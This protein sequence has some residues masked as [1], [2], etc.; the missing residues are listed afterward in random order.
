MAGKLKRRIL[1]VLGVGALALTMTYLVVGFLILPLAV[2]TL[3]PK[4]AND[5]INGEVAIGSVTINPISF[6]VQI[7]DIK[8]ADQEG[9]ELLELELIRFNINVLK[10]IFSLKPC[11]Q[12][13]SLRGG[14]VNVVRD[15]EGSINLLSVVEAQSELAEDEREPE[16]VETTQAQPPSL[17]DILVDLIEITGVS[18][19]F[20]DRSLEEVFQK[21]I[22]SIDLKIKD[23]QLLSTT[24]NNVVFSVVTDENEGVGLQ[25][26]FTLEPISAQGVFSIDSMNLAAISPYLE[27][28][29]ATVDSGVFNLSI[30]FS[31]QMDGA[32]LQAVIENAQIAVTEFSTSVVG[33]EEATLGF[34]EFGIRIPLVSALVPS[35]GEPTAVVHA[36][37]SL[38]YL[39]GKWVGSEISFLDLQKLRVKD[40]HFDLADMKASVES[41][42]ISEPE[43]FIERD[44]NG[45]IELMKLVPPKEEMDTETETSEVT[46]SEVAS[47]TPISEQPL[48]DLFIES[49]SVEKAA[50]RFLDRSVESPVDLEIYPLN[51]RVENISLDPEEVTKVALDLIYEDAG[52]LEVNGA[53]NLMDPG[54]DTSIGIQLN[55]FI[56]APLSAY[57]VDVIGL[58]INTGGVFSKLNYTI[59]QNQLKGS[60]Q[61]RV[62]RLRF[63]DRSRS[64]EGTV[65]PVKIVVAAMENGAGDI[66]L[67]LPLDGDLSDPKLDLWTPIRGVF[68]NLLT[69]AATAPFRLATGFTGGLLKTGLQ[70]IGVDTGKDHSQIPFDRGSIDFLD[71]PSDTLEVVSKTILN[72]PLL[73]L[74]LTGSIEPNA[75]AEA[76]KDTLIDQMIADFEG[77]SRSDKIKALYHHHFPTSK[78][79]EKTMSDE[80][81]SEENQPTNDVVST[82][83]TPAVGGFYFDEDSEKSE[84]VRKSYYMDGEKRSIAMRK[85]VRVEPKSKPEVEGKAAGSPDVSAE[86]TPKADEEKL[87]VHKMRTAIIEK[88]YGRRVQVDE[89]AS[90][91]AIVVRDLLISEYRVPEDRITVDE[92]V[93]RSG[94]KVLFDIAIS[95]SQ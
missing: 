41:I 30:P 87:S 43:A 2:K 54:K 26:S 64:F 77:N 5:A 52:E 28:I 10:T 86:P 18:V 27:G 39:S 59:Q 76:Y 3:V 58:P 21:T 50:F 92:S 46:A 17:P 6:F 9:T 65:P 71:D 8:L 11:V 68:T 67:E 84:P 61:F 83:K 93:S 72:K 82:T 37:V 16:E 53:L 7:K 32:D 38:E 4:F 35:E 47:V 51:L 48:I 33:Q 13:I 29:P 75:D 94:A 31:V 69:N 60:N 56:L 91:R 79:Q 63:G 24:D 70:Q 1:K 89:L 40:V 62:N 20:E 73:T 80:V 85:I 66:E 12:E 34:D 78:S 23:F 95:E 42:V 90:Q 88:V 15:E 14:S 22:R 25:S 74:Q 36:G 44:V 45:V 49:F 55:N 19:Q 81:K 57:S